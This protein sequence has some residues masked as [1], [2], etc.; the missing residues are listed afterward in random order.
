MS[1][2]FE[3][4]DVIS[5]ANC[6]EAKK[7]IGEEGYFRDDYQEDLVA[8]YKGIL[9]EIAPSLPVDCTFE[10]EKNNVYGLFLPADRVKQARSPH[11]RPFE[12]AKELKDALGVNELLGAKITYRR[13]DNPLYTYNGIVTKY[14]RMSSDDNNTI[15]CSI[16]IGGTV[17]SLRDLFN[18]YEWFSDR[19]GWQPFGVEE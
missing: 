13:K 15:F 9:Q 2:L 1:N 8:W 14:T 12:T 18:E 17:L 6:E 5:W 10:D 19:F 3:K 11:W 4:K 7:Y 16:S